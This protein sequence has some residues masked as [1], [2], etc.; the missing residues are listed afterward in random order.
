MGFFKFLGPITQLVLLFIKHWLERN[1][2]S[3]K[4][5]IETIEKAKVALKNKDV[6]GITDA[7][8]EYNAQQ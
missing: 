1:D 2:A 3:K 7:L 5:Q 4:K 6:R 8:D